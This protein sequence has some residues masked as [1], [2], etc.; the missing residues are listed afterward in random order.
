MKYKIQ[1]E[2]HNDKTYNGYADRPYWL[3]TLEGGQQVGL[4]DDGEWWGIGGQYSDDEY[5]KG[6]MRQ[7]IEQCNLTMKIY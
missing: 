3:V 6:E 4:K 7:V 1:R 5:I 2:H